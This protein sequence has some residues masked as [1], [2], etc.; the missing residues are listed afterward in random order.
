MK[1]LL[2]LEQITW[3]MVCPLLNNL[4]MMLFV[5]VRN[6]VIEIPAHNGQLEV[7]LRV[8]CFSHL[9]ALPAVLL[10]HLHLNRPTHVAPVEHETIGTVKAK[11]IFT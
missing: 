2:F 10:A 9:D 1:L 3:G 11:L 8:E 6:T 4:R 5:S 7:T